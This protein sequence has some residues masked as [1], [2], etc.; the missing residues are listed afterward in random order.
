MLFSFVIPPFLQLWHRRPA[1][2]GQ[3]APGSV[4][5]CVFLY[6]HNHMTMCAFSIARKALTYRSPAWDRLNFEQLISFRQER[7]D[8]YKKT[9]KYHVPNTHPITAADDDRRQA[10]VYVWLCVNLRC[11]YE[12][13]R[14][15][16]GLKSGLYLRG[17]F[18][19]GTSWWTLSCPHAHKHPH[20]VLERYAKEKKKHLD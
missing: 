10:S 13:I 18:P 12:E 17:S 16:Q 1:A 11:E 15:T 3:M 2:P 6:V 9:F 7:P 5:V 8:D 14:W 19:A 20:V 4:F